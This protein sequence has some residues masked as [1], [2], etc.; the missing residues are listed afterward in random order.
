MLI[1]IFKL[2]GINHFRHFE[3]KCWLLHEKIQN[4]YQTTNQASIKACNYVLGT[5]CAIVLLKY[6][7]VLQTT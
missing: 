2:N 1:F 7:S 6:K 5:F 4:D 3:E